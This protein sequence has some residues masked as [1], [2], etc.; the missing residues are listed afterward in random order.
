M[1]VLGTFVK[2]A[3]TGLSHWLSFRA[4]GAELDFGIVIT[5]AVLAGLVAY[6]PVAFNGLGT[7]EFTAMTLYRV[8]NVPDYQVLATYVILRAGNFLTAALGLFL[9]RLFNPKP[10]RLFIRRYPNF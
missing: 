9:S 5:V 4:I 6:V 1:N 3:T 2:L 8:S 7:V 10:S